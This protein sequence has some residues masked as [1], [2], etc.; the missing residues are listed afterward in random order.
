[1][2][3]NLL[4]YLDRFKGEF[5]KTTN[6]LSSADI[7]NNKD[8]YQKVSRRYA[9]LKDLLKLLD[10][11]QAFKKNKEGV[12]S[13]LASP[14]EDEG[15]LELARQELTQVDRELIR[16]EG[17]FYGRLSENRERIS[18]F[19]IEIRPG[20][21][22]QEAALF[23]GDLFRMYS[24]FIT[25]HPQWKMEVIDASPTELGGYKEVIFSV[26]GPSSFAYLKYESGVHRVQRVPMTETSGRVHT[27][28]A[29]VVV[30]REPDEVEFKIEPKDLHIEVC[31]ASG[32]G[33]QHVNKT[34]SAVRMVHLPTGVTVQCQD[35][36]S[37]I[38]NREKAMRVLRARVLALQ[39]QQQ[40]AKLS[41]ERRGQ[42]GSGD[43]SE[44]I[45]TYNYPQNRITDHRVDVTLY[46]LN[47]ILEGNLDDLIT[48]LILAER[49]SVLE[50]FFHE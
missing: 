32:A 27:S 37:Q 23:C 30:L 26:K 36:R 10:T 46:N 40:E 16:L 43:R 50:A 18:S 38:K 47:G 7:F 44:K 4:D 22:G 48:P 34:E 14:A 39:A 3:K 35:E 9:F 19:I 49:E 5:E 6:R 45:R 20:T 2:E 12:C 21:G 41:Q 29:S 15:V 1:M 11:Y 24:K 42:I 31:R 25:G 28:T 17:A 13:I 33:G 8:E